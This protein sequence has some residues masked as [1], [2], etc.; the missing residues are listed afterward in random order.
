M[1]L[2]EPAKSV[3]LVT[4]LLA[5]GCAKPLDHTARPATA[6]RVIAPTSAAAPKVEDADDSP[7]PDRF[8]IFAMI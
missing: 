5:I 3:F 1:E 7:V 2:S 6:R 8:W 4:C